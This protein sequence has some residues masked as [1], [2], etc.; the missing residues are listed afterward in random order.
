MYPIVQ[1]LGV[2]ES[3]S[4]LAGV[5]VHNF[6]MTKKELEL[7]PSELPTLAKNSVFPI[8]MLPRKNVLGLL[9]KEISCSV[10]KVHG[11]IFSGAR[12]NVTKFAVRPLSQP[13][14]I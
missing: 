6:L 11:A 4:S 2:L 5:C 7:K 9:D 13:I 10:W 12:N 3:E 1:D 8:K 14:Y